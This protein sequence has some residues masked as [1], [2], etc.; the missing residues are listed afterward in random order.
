MEFDVAVLAVVV[1]R[2]YLLSGKV[3]ILRV[4]K[5]TATVA[6]L[7]KHRLD[8]MW[9]NVLDAAPHHGVIAF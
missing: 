3:V 8:H 2:E 4:D 1:E 5:N 6:W 9:D 7:N